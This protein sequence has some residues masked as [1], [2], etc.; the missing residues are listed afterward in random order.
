LE[1]ALKYVWTLRDEATCWRVAHLWSNK[2]SAEDRKLAAITG[3][4]SLEPEQAIETAQFVL[5]A[6]SRGQPG[7]PLISYLDEAKF[8]AENT[9]SDELGHYLVACFW[10]LPKPEQL[11]FRD[12]VVK[13]CAERIAA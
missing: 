13:A 10:A 6:M 9:H 12:Y 7:P 8:W 11:R 4:M 3:L 2:L 5:N 1:H